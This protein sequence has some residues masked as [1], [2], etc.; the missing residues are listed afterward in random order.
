MTHHQARARSNADQ[1][2]RQR[3]RRVAR[4][5]TSEARRIACEHQFAAML[6]ERLQPAADLN[7]PV[8]QRSRETYH[9]F[10]Q[11]SATEAEVL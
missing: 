5:H 11:R 9:A 1:A 10:L 6:A 2:H 8:I 7:A 4:L 3:Q